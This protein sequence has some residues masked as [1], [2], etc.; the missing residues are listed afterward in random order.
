MYK[1]VKFFLKRLKRFSSTFNQ[2]THFITSFKAGTFYLLLFQYIDILVE[3]LIK[4]WYLF[5][6]PKKGKYLI[7]WE[8]VEIVVSVLNVLAS[9]LATPISVE[10]AHRPVIS[11]I[12]IDDDDGWRR[13]QGGQT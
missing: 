11:S 12:A 3:K 4:I 10:S 2:S 5:G 1:S 8:N 13:V 9:T 6:N 7:T